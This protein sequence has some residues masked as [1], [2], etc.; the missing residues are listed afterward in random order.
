M[1]DKKKHDR[2]NTTR[3]EKTREDNTDNNTLFTLVA[4]LA[5]LNICVP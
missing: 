4:I 3:Q 2:Q 5:N 1:E